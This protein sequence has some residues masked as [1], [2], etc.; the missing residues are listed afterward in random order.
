MSETT[1][2]IKQMLG[3][4]KSPT[5]IKKELNLK[6]FGSIYRIKKQLENTPQTAE[7]KNID[8]TIDKP[9]EI[10]EPKVENVEPKLSDIKVNEIDEKEEAKE[11]ADQFKA[12][13]E[14][15]EAPKVNPEEFKIETNQ[16]IKEETKTIDNKVDIEELS[17]FIPS[18][19]S[20]F[21]KSRGL[22]DLTDQQKEK[23]KKHTNSVIEK[24]A[25]E[26]ITNNA[27]LINLGLDVLTIS[28]QKADE[29]NK[30]KALEKINKIQQMDINKTPEQKIK[31][32]TKPEPKPEEPIVLKRV[33]KTP[34][35]DDL[36]EE[37]RVELATKGTFHGKQLSEFTLS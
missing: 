14:T 1:E 8:K 5:E 13:N 12:L 21:F 10:T 24:R 22:S 6:S 20:V 15:E 17:D 2:K 25:P 32:E 9:K 29:L 7:F 16:P 34:L 33:F 18:F 31:E 37:E 27:D 36:T 28:V 26:I 23:L 30:K 4:G 19:L 35:P 11:I 3:E